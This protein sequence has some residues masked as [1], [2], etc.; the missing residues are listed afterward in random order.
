MTSSPGLEQK[1]ARQLGRY[2][3]FRAIAK[4]GMA[5]VHL[6]RLN[7]P[8][9]FARTVAIKRMH[10][11][12]VADPEFVSMFVDEARLAARIHHP[13]VVQTLDVIELEEELFI[14]M[15]YVHGD[16]L[17]HLTKVA[18]VVEPKIA[19][20]IVAAALNGLH[21]AHEA[22]S[23]S[24]EP[25]KVV[26]R[27]VSPQNI[28]VGADGVPRVLDFGV[29]KAAKRI[30]S[31]SSGEI[32][33][34][35]RYMPPEQLRGDPIDRRADIYAAG[36]VLFEALTGTRY[37]DKEEPAAIMLRTLS[38]P[39]TPPSARRPDLP[40]ALD[41][42][43]LKAL[44]PEREQRFA[45]AEEMALA[46]EDAVGLASPARIA[47]WV[48]E[49]GGPILA[50]RAKRVAEVEQARDVM[51]EAT[52]PRT[53]SPE[54]RASAPGHPT[55]SPGQPTSSPGQP[56]SSPGQPTSSPELLPSEVPSAASNLTAALPPRASVRTR[57][58]WIALGASAV[59]ITFG[60]IATIRV[61]AGSG[62]SAASP[63][64]SAPL[65]SASPTPV[66]ESAVP[67][68]TAE[69]ATATA[70]PAS[71]PTVAV[72]LDSVPAA[73]ASAAPAAAPVRVAPHRPTPAPHPTST[74]DL[75][76]RR[77]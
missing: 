60:V 49:V 24:G 20:S 31:T 38:A 70:A 71:A 12:F 68:A 69:V 41:A 56:T 42:I 37:T 33:G 34:K 28:L 6:G 45:T 5:S 55:S 54:L 9:G 62:S 66:A 63:S 43:V 14:V 19:A 75:F 67:T 2:T 73:S 59:F 52:V 57:S 53:S 7:G 58:A 47:R 29:A 26:H 11:Q 23:E 15:E 32:K 3:L 65:F 8:V 25:L 48:A 74:A 64:D 4:G 13:N 76:R 35:V 36:I 77:H 39:P 18:K 30:Q 44:A 72:E 46:I 1:S 10:E 50:E 51:D 17:S 40:K 22:K 21:A 16:S 27:D 61:I